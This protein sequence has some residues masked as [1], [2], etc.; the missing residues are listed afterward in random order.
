MFVAA[1]DE[2][3]RR[4]GS[5]ASATAHAFAWCKKSSSTGNARID[6]PMI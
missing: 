2:P 5:H 3:V 4:L 6:S 1:T